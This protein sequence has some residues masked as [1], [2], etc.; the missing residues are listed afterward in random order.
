MH[1]ISCFTSFGRLLLCIALTT[2]ALVPEAWAGTVDPPLHLLFSGKN[3][4]IAG[5]L[6]EINPPSRLVF[7][8]DAVIGGQSDVPE[9]IDVL[10]DTATV[11]SVALGEHY[12]FAYT[13]IHRDKRMPGQVALNKRGAV[14][15]SS[16]GLEP[17]LFPDSA[18]LRHV[19]AAADSEEKRDSPTLLRLMLK[20]LKSDDAKLQYL[21]A[22]QITLDGDLG[23]MLTD[24]NRALLRKVVADTRGSTALRFN[25]LQATY[26][27]PDLYGEWGMSE[28]QEVLATT[29]LDG[30]PD[31]PKDP[32]AL[33]LLAFDIAQ[34]PEA[35][36]PKEL[37]ARWLRSP[38]RLFRE[39]SARVLEAKFPGEQRDLY[40]QALRDPTLND[41]GRKFLVDQLQRLDGHHPEQAV[42][43]QGPE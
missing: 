23:A 42:H 36:L 40:A 21:A 17:A 9:L 20:T 15:V 34:K 10:A 39:Q 3:R 6:K 30:Y 14:L 8:R 13:S 19:L 1:S 11:K 31:G 12:V 26:L 7:E 2:C 27:H 37:I 41:E 24:K 43:K 28:A 29:P 33:V 18:A 22:A 32:T 16:T 25:L 5:T 4:L 38:R 35:G